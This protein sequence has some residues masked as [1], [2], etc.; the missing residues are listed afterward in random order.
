MNSV[1][2]AVEGTAFHAP[3]R[4]GVEMLENCLIEVD[5]DGRIIEVVNPERRDHGVRRA[6]AADAGILVSLGPG[7]YLMPGL[8]DLHVHAPQWP[9]MGKALDV[10]LEVWLQKYTFPLESRYA[11]IDFARAVYGELV[12]N[13]LANGTTTAMYFATVH[14]EASLAL[15]EIC[16]EKGQRALV[17]KV[18][19]DDPEQCP[20]YYRDQTAA[21]ALADTRRFIEAVRALD[22]GD[23]PRVLPVITPR[24]IPSCSDDA[25]QGL[26]ILAAEL[27]CH[28]QTHCSESDWANTFVRA[29]MGKSDAASLGEFGLLTRRTVLAHANFIDSRDMTLIRAHGAGV[30]HCPL[31]NV[32]FANAVFPLR[33]ALESGMHVGLGTDISAG[34]SPSLFDGCRHAL[35]ASRVLHSGV[36]AHL[37]PGE[38]GAD[39]EPISHHE[40][41]W[42]ATAGGAE[43]LDLPIGSFQAGY[44]F[45]ALLVDTNAAASNV[46]IRHG[47]DAI[48]DVFQKLVLNASR[49]DIASVWVGGRRVL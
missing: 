27:G 29:R 2:L 17:G 13:L 22:P 24:F 3:R 46:R 5:R 25:L 16:L 32:Y 30:A 19:M 33:A 15:A 37:S 38:R 43:A 23:R 34:Y 35:S 48:E 21:Q 42:L 6:A 45:D 28:V 4:G 36:H 9:Q 11:D 40:A 1:S 49:A 31:S 18:V 41:F 8:V 26:G 39:G 7:Q 20:P 14:L 44:E 12:D 47:S 10:P